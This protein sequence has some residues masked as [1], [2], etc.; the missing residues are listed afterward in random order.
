MSFRR[1][2][3]GEPRPRRVYIGGGAAGF[4]VSYVP[5]ARA[6]EARALAWINRGSG[7]VLGGFGTLALAAAWA[8]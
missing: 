6:M 1:F 5:R 4:S 8:S 7:L 2:V 3:D